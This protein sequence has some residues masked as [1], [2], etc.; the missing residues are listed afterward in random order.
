MHSDGF[1]EPVC[2]GIF[3]L[4]TSDDTERLDRVIW[5][6]RNDF[7]RFSGTRRGWCNGERLDVALERGASA[8]QRAMLELARGPFAKVQCH[9]AFVQL[10]GGRSTVAQLEAHA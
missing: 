1:S 10:R 3:G 6:P 8:W 5:P 7:D 2:E 4:V 9:S